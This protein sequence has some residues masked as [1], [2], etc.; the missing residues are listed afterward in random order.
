MSDE[1]SR[2][3]AA[4]AAIR[5]GKQ[6]QARDLLQEELQHD[7]Q[8]FRAWLWLAGLAASPQ[9][10]LD[11][12][13]QAER[14]N[15]DDPGVRKARAWAGQR[16]ARQTASGQSAAAPPKTTALSERPQQPLT[17][18]T[19]TAASQRVD[20]LRSRQL[21]PDRHITHDQQLTVAEETSPRRR[22]LWF[23]MIFLFI[24][25]VVAS[26]MLWGD[27]ARQ[28]VSQGLAAGAPSGDANGVSVATATATLQTQLAGGEAEPVEVSFL[29][30][31][32]APAAN[33]TAPAGSDPPAQNATATPLALLP[34]SVNKSN[35]PRPT[36]TLTPSPT[37]TPTATPTPVPTFVSDD[38]VVV[39]GAVRPAGV[40]P[41]ERWI[42]VNLTTQS[43]VAYEG[44]NAVFNSLVSSGTWLHPTVTGEFRVW[45]RY[46]AQTM[47]GTRL[48]Y[49]YYLPNV[50]YV[51]YFYRD[52]ALH[53]T[54]WH[55]NFGT[56]M[57]HGCVNLPTPAA[58]WIF[59]W[60]SIGTLVNVH[61]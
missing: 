8:N 57:S 37:F 56:P 59:N 49:D 3:F 12:I 61:Y 14:L 9:A 19:E 33:N 21:A 52:Y 55:N 44:D 41:N 38:T 22:P 54:Y 35:N 15:P 58:E 32:F 4:Q 7:P 50:P 48:G 5:A 10:S 43:L 16:L 42:D 29:S 20:A 53:G 25:A 46:T 2:M 47:D 45:L 51:M 36:W 6:Q 40:G 13:R 31:Q 11:Y 17:G 18:E 24:A 27:E 1:S 60:S 30:G 23:A 39:G 26:A 28:L 34:K